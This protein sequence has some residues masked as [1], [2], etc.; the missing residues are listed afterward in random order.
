MAQLYG[1]LYEAGIPGDFKPLACVKLADGT[2]VLRTEVVE[3]SIDSITLEVNN[4]QVGSTDNSKNNTTYLKTKADGT[5]Y[6]EGSVT[7]SKGNPVVYVGNANILSATV[8]FAADAKHIQVENM[9]SSDKIY[10]SFD[11]G[12]TWR[13]IQTG[14]ILDIDCDAVASIDIK[15]DADTTPYEIITLE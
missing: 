12:V 15:A 6:I 4:I 8:T 7:V 14:Y 3:L 13:T 1:C 5:V 9:D 10:I 11:S 2:Y